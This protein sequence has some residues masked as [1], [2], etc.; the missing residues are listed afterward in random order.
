MHSLRLY[1]PNAL[2]SRINTVCPGMI[3]TAMTKGIEQAWK[4]SGSLVDDPADVAKIIA[5][6][7]CESSLNGE[8]IFVEGG[9]GWK[10]E[11]AFDALEP[12][13]LREEPSRTLAES[14][15]ALG[16][17]GPSLR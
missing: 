5:Q 13:W 4:A 1:S 12:L 17:V 15:R 9:R 11:Q 3:T 16:A 14:Q 7:A 10:F 6:V 2:G 8:S